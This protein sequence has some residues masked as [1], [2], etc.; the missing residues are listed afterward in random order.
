MAQVALGVATA[1][2]LVHQLAQ[3]GGA[4]QA[5][6]HQRLVETGEPCVVLAE[7]LEHFRTTVAK[8]IEILEKKRT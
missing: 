8:G 7:G 5:G 3:P 2:G 4:L 1:R 6:D